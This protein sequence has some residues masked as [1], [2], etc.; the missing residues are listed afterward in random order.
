MRE[1]SGR[2][3]DLNIQEGRGGSS[4][5]SGYGESYP[6]QV[7]GGEEYGY[8]LRQARDLIVKETLEQS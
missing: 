6:F 8:G 1:L 7:N 4:K 2:H 3:N 5:E